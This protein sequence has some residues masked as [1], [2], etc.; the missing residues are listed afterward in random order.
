MAY[1]VQVARLVP[2]HDEVDREPAEHAELGEVAPDH[3]GG[4]GDRRGVRRGR[5]GT[6]SRGTSGRSRHRAAGR[7]WTAARRVPSGRARIWTLGLVRAVAGDPLLDDAAV[8]GERRQVDVDGQVVGLQAPSRAPGPGSPPRSAGDP[9]A[10]RPR[11]STSA[12]PAPETPSLSLTIASVSVGLRGAHRAR[13]RR[14]GRRRRGGPRRP[15]G[16]ARRAPRTAGGSR[17]CCRVGQPGVRAVHRDAE[18][19]RDVPLEVGGVVGDQVADAPG[20]G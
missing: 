1:G 19:E 11:R 20:S 18:A 7:A 17:S 10:G 9:G 15:A 3:H 14:R 5:R 12:L 8:R 2:D 13:W 6:R 4:L 16:T